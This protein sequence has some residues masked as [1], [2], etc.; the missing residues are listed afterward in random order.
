MAA[1]G[2]ALFVHLSSDECDGP[3]ASCLKVIIPSTTCTSQYPLMFGVWWGKG[4]T[5]TG[6]NVC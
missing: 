5:K 4:Y 2:M 1:S 6:E 3:K